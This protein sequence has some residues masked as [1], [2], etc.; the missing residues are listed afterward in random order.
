MPS[1]NSRFRA[2]RCPPSTALPPVGAINLVNKIR[3]EPVPRDSV[4]IPPQRI[5]AR[6]TFASR[7]LPLRY[8]QYGGS[9]GAPIIKNRTFGFFNYEEYRLR[10]S[11][12]R[13]SS[14]PIEEWRNGD[15]R[16]LRTAQ[17]QQIQIFDPDNAAEPER[18]RTDPRSFPE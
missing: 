10:S 15:F 6:N 4:R 1:K 11:T 13:I 8:N 12:P 3:H 9:L 5:D 7:K 14:V 17:G 2:V 16:N 18:R